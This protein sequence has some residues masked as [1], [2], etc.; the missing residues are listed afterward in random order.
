MTF[1]TKK[2][3]FEMIKTLLKEEMICI[4]ELTIKILYNNLPQFHAT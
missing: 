2:M 4:F 3:A 1:E